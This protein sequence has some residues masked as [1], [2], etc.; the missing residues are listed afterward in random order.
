MREHKGW[1]KAR[2]NWDLPTDETGYVPCDA[3]VASEGV[4]M[5][6]VHRHNLKPLSEACGYPITSIAKD[7]FRHTSCALVAV[8][9]HSSKMAKDKHRNIGV[10]AFD[11]VRH[12][13]PCILS[14]AWN[15]ASLEPMAIATQEIQSRIRNLDFI[16]F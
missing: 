11:V 7:A 12:D 8:L 6:V 1:N 15:T 9:R 5:M 2:K 3:V 16:P 13:K 4:L 14:R 10:L